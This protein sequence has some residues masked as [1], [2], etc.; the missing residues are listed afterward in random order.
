MIRG[1]VTCDREGMSVREIRSLTVSRVSHD[2]TTWETDANSTPTN[3]VSPRGASIL[4]WM[5]RVA[6][7]LRRVRSKSDPR[8]VITLFVLIPEELPRTG[9]R[10]VG[11]PRDFRGHGNIVAF[12]RR[13]KF[14]SLHRKKNHVSKSKM[15]KAVEFFFD[16][17]VKYKN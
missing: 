15:R 10:R 9:S 4:M 8:D 2:R 11:G 16:K 13:N 7:P 5:H 14:L 17:Y 1:G 3:S 12:A 6:A